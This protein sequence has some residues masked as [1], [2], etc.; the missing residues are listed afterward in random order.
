MNKRVVLIV[1]IVLLLV[2]TIAVYLIYPIFN[3][4]EKN[5][6]IAIKEGSIIAEGIFLPSAHEVK[7]KAIVIDDNGKNILRFED[8][9]TING[10]D[11]RIYL[12]T[13]L[14]V[15]D[16]IDLGPIKATKG[17]INYELDNSVD[18]EKYDNVLVWC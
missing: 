3:V 11:L 12:S 9:E 10:P 4:V 13:G 8:F 17:N 15:T 2:I 5:E 16:A 18:L 14:D 6:E 7:G 1:G